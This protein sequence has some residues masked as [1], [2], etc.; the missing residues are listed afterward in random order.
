MGISVPFGC[1]LARSLP[2]FVWFSMSPRAPRQANC[3]ESVLLTHR[4]EGNQ[5]GP[6][7]DSRSSAILGMQRNWGKSSGFSSLCVL[8]FTLSHSFPCCLQRYCPMY[9][10]PPWPFPSGC[11]ILSY[12]RLCCMVSAITL[13]VYRQPAFC[14]ILRS[15]AVCICHVQFQFCQRNFRSMS[16]LSACPTVPTLG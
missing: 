7:M 14:I 16:L 11:L 13:H 1:G 6:C 4:S 5:R 9:E 10:S 2:V 15:P 8:V 3:W 12:F